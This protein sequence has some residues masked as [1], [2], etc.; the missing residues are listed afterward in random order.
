MGLDK[1]ISC[2]KR[3]SNFPE[4]YAGLVYLPVYFGVSALKPSTAGNRSQEGPSLCIRTEAAL[5][6]PLI[7]PNSA[8]TSLTQWDLGANRRVRSARSDNLEPS[9]P[10]TM[11]RTRSFNGLVRSAQPT[12]RFRAWLRTRSPQLRRCSRCPNLPERPSL[13]SLCSP[14]RPRAAPPRRPRRC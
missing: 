6:W 3:W 2:M 13:W 7:L 8:C 4:V 9:N 1:P 5:P 10:V 14:R 12:P 11:L